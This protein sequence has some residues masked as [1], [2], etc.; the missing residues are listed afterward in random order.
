MTVKTNVESADNKACCCH[1][2]ATPRTEKFQSDLQKR[3]NR[4]IGQLNGV[5]NMLEDNRYCGDVLIQLAAVENALHSVSTMI[6]QDH[7][8]TCVVE[9]IR[10]G[11]D[12]VINETIGLIKKFS[13]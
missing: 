2:K 10:S 5:K 6:L 8:E 13:R 4:A 12:E 9:Q 1:H 7:L 3:L 11:N